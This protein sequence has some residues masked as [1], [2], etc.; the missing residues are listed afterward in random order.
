MPRP[1]KQHTPKGT[2]TTSK[3]AQVNISLSP[4][5]L[6]ALGRIAKDQRRTVASVCRLILEDATGTAPE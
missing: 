3:R 2:T 1:K 6:D 5:T 4:R